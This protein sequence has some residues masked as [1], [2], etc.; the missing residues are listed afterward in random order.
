MALRAAVGELRKAAAEG[1]L[2]TREAYK[3]GVPRQPNDKHT[4]R[5]DLNVGDTGPTGSDVTPH[6]RTHRFF[7]DF[8]GHNEALSDSRTLIDADRANVGSRG[9]FTVVIAPPLNAYGDPIQHFDDLDLGLNKFGIDQTG[10]I[11]QFMA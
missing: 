5:N 10:L 2:T 4:F 6:P 1:R 8:I 7:R 3:R 11:P 9:S